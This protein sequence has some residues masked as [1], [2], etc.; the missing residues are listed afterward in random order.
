MALDSR[1]RGSEVREGWTGLATREFREDFVGAERK[2]GFCTGSGIIA[3]QP[4]VDSEGT[5]LPALGDF[6]G[7]AWGVTPYERA[8][9]EPGGKGDADP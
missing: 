7:T 2:T 5:L 3:Q 4:A 1:K 8:R 9:K 6:L